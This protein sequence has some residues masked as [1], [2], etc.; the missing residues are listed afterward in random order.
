LSG[1]INVYFF[2]K[3]IGIFEKFAKM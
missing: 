3:L 2:I 1:F